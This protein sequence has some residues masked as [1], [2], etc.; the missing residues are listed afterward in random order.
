MFY[1][2]KLLLDMVPQL[3]IMPVVL[4]SRIRLV[5]PHILPI[6]TGIADEVLSCPPQVDERGGATLV[7]AEIF[8]FNQSGRARTMREMQ[9]ILDFPPVCL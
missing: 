4:L 1:V 3:T 7:S 8:R 6:T 5:P 2:T 9:K